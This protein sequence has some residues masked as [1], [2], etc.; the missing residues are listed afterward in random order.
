MIKVLCFLFQMRDNFTLWW[1]FKI[2]NFIEVRQLAVCLV[3][4]THPVLVGVPAVCLSINV[5][6]MIR[7]K[8]TMSCHMGS[9]YFFSKRKPKQPYTQYRF[10]SNVGKLPL[11]R[12]SWIFWGFPVVRFLDSKI[13]FLNFQANDILVS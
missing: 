5:I 13:G 1:A 7:F 3:W 9:K 2:R 8:E 12:V 11:L 10:I 4:K 6:L